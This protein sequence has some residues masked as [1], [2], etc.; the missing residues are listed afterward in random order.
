MRRS[1]TVT[2]AM[3][4]VS[5]KLPTELDEALDELARRRRTSRSKLVREAIEGLAREDRPSTT[6]LA[7]ELVGSLSGAAD[8]AT[9]P[10]HFAGYGK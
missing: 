3:R 2:K 4:T 5:F 7:G 10:E 8:L 1:N 9:N 6:A